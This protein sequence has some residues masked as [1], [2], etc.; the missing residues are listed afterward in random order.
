MIKLNVPYYSQRLDVLDPEWKSRSC[1]TCA[2]KM[3]MEF[4]GPEK[5]NLDDLTKEGLA[6][7]AYLNGVGWIHQG[8]IDLAKKHGF[9]NSFRKEWLEDKKQDGIG[10]ITENLEKN[11]PVLA[12]VKNAG[13]GH[14]ILIVGLKGSGEAP[15]GFYF[16]D[17]NAYRAVEGE[18]KFL[19]LPEFLKVWKGRIIVISK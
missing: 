5:I 3:A 8:L 16:H 1:G 19:N 12:S 10:F 13:G 9:K 6:F 17:P 11:I 18:F 14:I 15:E 2:F 7:G 4:L